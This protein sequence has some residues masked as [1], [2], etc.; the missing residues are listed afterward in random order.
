VLLEHGE[1]LSAAGGVDEAE[2]LL[3]EA[4]EIFAALEAAPWLERLDAL[5]PTAV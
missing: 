4:R 3:T 2:P 5:A 1:W